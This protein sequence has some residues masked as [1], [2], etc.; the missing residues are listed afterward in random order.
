MK[1]SCVFRASGPTD[2]WLVRDWLE[3]NG[4]QVL[5]RG[6]LVSVAG[7]IPFPE[8]WPTVWVPEPEKELADEAMRLFRG[9]RLVRD[10]WT[11][12]SCGEVNEPSF[13]SCWQCE[14]ER[15]SADPA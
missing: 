6:D 10:P 14:T 8:A 11:C 1:W 15:P 7:Q 13:D 9:P 3:R 5:V 2:A 4:L 12:P